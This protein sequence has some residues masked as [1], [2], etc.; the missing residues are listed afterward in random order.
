[1]TYFDATEA[2]LT[3]IK[4]SCGF[5]FVL[6]AV[7]GSALLKFIT[8]HTIGFFIALY[9]LVPINNFKGL[10]LDVRRTTRAYAYSI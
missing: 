1:M 5:K 8:H 2:W 4:G 3:Y 9:F 7:L 6:Q 10:S